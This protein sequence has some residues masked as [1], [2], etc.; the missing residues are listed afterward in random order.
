MVVDGID[1][2]FVGLGIPGLKESGR[3]AFAKTRRFIECESGILVTNVDASA[4]NA[5]PVLW[6]KTWIFL[7]DD[8]G[9]IP[10]AISIFPRAIR[11]FNNAVLAGSSIVGL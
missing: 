3:M 11:I 2:G 7:T 6:T 10:I 5:V 4:F 1:D 9:C 8:H